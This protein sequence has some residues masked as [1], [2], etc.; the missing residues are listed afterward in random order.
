MISS[1]GLDE[2]D[3]TPADAPST[4]AATAEAVE[5]L[6]EC[7]PLTLP[8]CKHLPYNI[9]SYPNLVGHVNK[10]VLLRDLVAFRELLDAECSHLAQV[11]L[12][13]S[14]MVLKPRRRKERYTG[15]YKNGIYSQ[16]G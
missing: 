8:L 15:C 2:L 1:Q 3:T 13:F 11:S 16:K 14:L 9:T 10:E 5:E 4:E 12:V 6:R 7:S